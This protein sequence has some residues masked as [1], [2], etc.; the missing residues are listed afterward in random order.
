MRIPDVPRG[1]YR[2]VVAGA[3][4]A[5]VLEV[6]ALGQRDVGRPVAF[7]LLFI[8]A[9]LVAGVVDPPPLA[10]R[11]L[12]VGFRNVLGVA[13][14]LFG[15]RDRRSLELFVPVVLARLPEYPDRS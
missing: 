10:R 5:P 6:V 1:S 15:I 4:E 7:G 3:R 2:V 12:L 13:L 11:D 9:V 14:L 8:L